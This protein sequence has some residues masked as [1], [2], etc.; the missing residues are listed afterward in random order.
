MKQCKGVNFY[1]SY[2]LPPIDVL[3]AVEAMDEMESFKPGIG[4]G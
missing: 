2:H 3:D 1:I 4:R